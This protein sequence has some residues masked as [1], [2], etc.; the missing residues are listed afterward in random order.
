MKSVR[1]AIV[2]PALNESEAITAVVQGISTYG[3]PIVVNDGSTDN[4]EQL[5]SAAGA[6]VVSH[7]A[8]HGYD[9]ALASGLA[10]AIEEGF[11]FAMT[12]DG[13][14][15]HEPMGIESVLEGLLGGA[16]LVV[17][18]RGN[19]QRASEKLFAYLAKALW[20]IS[21]PLCGVKGYRLS[22]LK[23]VCRLCSYPSIGTELAI[24][25]IRSR[26]NVRQVPVETH[27]RKDKSRFGT[28][29]YAN[30]LIFRA[31]LLGLVLARA[32]AV[33]KVIERDLAS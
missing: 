3:V 2:I 10:K 23:A 15:Q 12:V 8:S 9:Y 32:Y 24:R 6:L 4:T 21:D 18:V 16:D 27:D 31:M 30:W 29:C 7:E 33:K 13:D 22:R 26:W 14:G 19:F 25:A 11:D 17:G 20:G 1:V 28:G 5:A